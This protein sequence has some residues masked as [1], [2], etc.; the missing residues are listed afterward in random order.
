M[1]T[2]DE[3]GAGVSRC[4]IEMQRNVGAHQDNVFLDV[5]ATTTSRVQSV[6][7]GIG[8]AY[9]LCRLVL[10]CRLRGLQLTS[11]AAI[12]EGARKLLPQRHW[13]D[14]SID[15]AVREGAIVSE[16]VSADRQHE[17]CPTHAACRLN[18]SRKWSRIL[19]VILRMRFAALYE[20]R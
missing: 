9:V 12:T 13:R 2:R 15:A 16:S 8:E 14:D 5:L 20:M 6:D 19:P 18:S 1:T 4:S 17:D 3:D 11:Q 7:R 10:L